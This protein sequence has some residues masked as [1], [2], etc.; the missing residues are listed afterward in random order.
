M[1]EGEPREVEAGTVLFT[2]RAAEAVF[3]ELRTRILKRRCTDTAGSRP[4]LMESLVSHQSLL[5]KRAGRAGH[6]VGKGDSFDSQ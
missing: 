1:V 2:A 3:R 4:L 5:C 6:V